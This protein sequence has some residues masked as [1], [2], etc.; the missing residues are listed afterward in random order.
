MALHAEDIKN[1]AKLMGSDLVIA[2]MGPTGSGKSNLIDTLT[3]Q[4]GRRAGSY[5]E[6]CTTEVRAVRLFNHS[7]Y[8]DRLVFV[9]TP[10]FDDTNKSDLEI[11]EMISKW[12]QKVYEKSIKLAGIVYLHRI[13]DN[14]MAGS[15][16]RN[17]RMFGELCGDQAVKKVVLVTTMWDKAYSLAPG[18]QK[19]QDREQEKLVSREKDLFER[20]W[21]TMIDHGASTARFTNS[22]HSAWNIIEVILSHQEAEVLLLQEEI[23]DLKRALNETQAGKTLYSDLQ[24]LLAE[25][26]DTVRSLA[27]QARVESNPQLARQLE[28]E[29]KRIQK[30]FDK[31]FGEIKNLKITM[32]KRIM[33]F[34]FGKKSRARSLHF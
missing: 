17:L 7:V 12:L 26:R 29:L 34:L 8:G 27:Q 23:V 21:K 14:R 31:T 2:F 20:Y 16:H 6:S 1:A 19:D 33:L 11:L 4:P 15:P 24:K 18:K 30:D 22:S 10:G 9:D 3:G 28:A 32:G 5:L 25:Q 13:T